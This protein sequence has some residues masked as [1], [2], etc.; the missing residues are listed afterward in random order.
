MFQQTACF[1]AFGDAKTGELLSARPFVI[2]GL[3]TLDLGS[4]L[5]VVLLCLVGCIEGVLQSDE[6]FAR[7]EG[8]Q[9]GL[10]GLELL[11]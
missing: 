6:V 8:I 10:L 2:C 5:L 9:N 3:L 7:L 11:G 4:G 1:Q